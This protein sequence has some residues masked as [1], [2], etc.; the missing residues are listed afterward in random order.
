MN[1]F[2]LTDRTHY[3]MGVGKCARARYHSK[4]SG[5]SGYGLVRKAES[6]PL[7]TGTYAHVA[8]GHL[9]SYMQKTDQLPTTAVVREAVTLATNEYDKILTARGF[10]GLMAS[11]TTE[12]VI[13]EQ[14]ALITGMTW[15]FA[16]KILPWWHKEFRTLQVEQEGLYVLDCTCGA[17]IGAPASQHTNCH[18]IALQI[19][20]DV[21]GER[22]I[23]PNI[24]AYAEIKTTGKDFGPFTEEWESRPQLS[25]GTLNI[26]EQYQG[27]QISELW[28]FGLYKGYREKIYDDQDRIVGK[29]QASVFCQGYRRPGNPPV[30]AEDWKPTYRYVNEQGQK[31]QVTKDYQK[32]SIWEL[33]D[34]P[35]WLTNKAADPLMSAAEC[36][37]R[38]LPDDVIAKQLFVLGPL[39]R[40]DLQVEMLKRQISAEERRWQQIVW[41]LYNSG[42]DWGT[43]DFQQLLDQLVPCSWNCRP[44]GADHACQY[45]PLCYRHD[46]WQTPELIGFVSRTPHHTSELDQMKERGLVPTVGGVVE[47]QD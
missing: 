44:Y 41:A 20:Q 9:F 4:H 11:S 43:E 29:R 7:A 39:N 23:N 8:T 22:R 21:I 12:A 19:R 34:W 36:W 1:T 13:T 46:G 6:L 37:A 40:Q 47:E 24:L 2:W 35:I 3:E 14:C 15:A 45:E 17:G 31:K 30:A 27:R 5:P 18:G 16:L 42:L 10:R 26:P 25:L 32:A 33:H 38:S 28:V